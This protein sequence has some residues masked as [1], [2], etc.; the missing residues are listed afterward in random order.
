MREN[1]VMF[2]VSIIVIIMVTMPYIYA[3][4]ASDSSHVFGGFLINPID[5]HSYLA[6]MQLGYR[7]E[8]KFTLPY[9][10]EKGE[11]AFLFLFYIFLG[12]L[13]RILNAD[14]IVIFQI[15]RVAGAIFLLWSL[16]R[17]I[18]NIFSQARERIIWFIISAMGAGLGWIA[19]LFGMFTSDFWVAEAFPFLSIYTNPHFTI[20]LGLMLIVLAASRGLSPLVSLSLGLILGIVQPFAVVIVAMVLFVSSAFDLTST[21]GTF[22]QRIVKSKL[23]E[24]A[25][26]FSIGGGGILG[27]QLYVIYNDPLLSN[28]NIQNIT[29]SPQ[30]LDL[31]ISLSPCLV[32]GLFGL[33][34]AWETEQGKLMI[35]WTFL[36][37]GLIIVPWNLQRR[38]MTG[39]YVP[40]SCL[41]VFGLRT[42]NDKVNISNRISMILLIIFALP[43]NWIIIYSGLQASN[44]LDPAIY[45]DSGLVEAFDWIED[46]IPHESV[47]LTDEIT[48]LYIPSWT[49]RRVVYGHPFETVNAEVQLDYL[50]DFFDKKLSG[51]NVT[52]QLTERGVDYVLLLRANGPDDEDWLGAKLSLLY[53]NTDVSIYEVK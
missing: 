40:I 42:L 50:D 44:T 30:A 18:L 38:F 3:F 36:S 34:N 35:L 26:F 24:K 17:F 33:K 11:G 32:L 1:R 4:Q 14:L 8:W 39:I 27:Y 7:G 41:A 9:T 25:I 5:G 2:G 13:A 6:K 21:T 16:R 23:A 45:L 46:N 20:G 29:P 12:H 37:L 15:A 53:E 52:P 49:G 47:F 31:F 28:W 48:G 43:T 22:F 51:D 19:V 10:A